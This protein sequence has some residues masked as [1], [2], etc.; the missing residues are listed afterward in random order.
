MK[1]WN[2]I[3]EEMMKNPS[4]TVC[5][6]NAKMNYEELVIF[7]EAFAEKLR[8]EKCCAVLCN[9]E[10]AT[11][12]GLLSC[13]AA[14]VTAVPVSMR[15]GEQHCKKIFDTICPTA[16]ITDMYGE[17]AIL[18]FDDGEY[19]EPDIPPALIM[20]TSGTTGA[21]K[22]AMLSEANIMTNV[23]DICAYF[24]LNTADRILIAR[25]L[26]HCAVLTG[27]F[28]TSL[29][30]GV[31]IRF[32]S[33]AFNPLELLN[34]IAKQEI[35]TFC[36]TPTLLSMLAS[37]LRKGQASTLKNICVSGE[38]MSAETGKK[39]AN[40]FPD[41][42]IYHVY[43]L[44]EAC[45]RVS[46]LSPKEFANKP[47][48]VGF[49]LRSVSLKIITSSG[50]IAKANEIGML[51]VKGE[52]IMTGY[53]N[54]PEQSA[55][56]LCDGWLCT[57]DMALT[58][59]DGFLK[60]KGRSDNL[61]I[62]AGMNIYPQEIEEA[63]KKDKRVREVLAYGYHDDRLGVQIGLK[64]VG[65]F[66]NTDEVKQI[67]KTLLPPFQIPTLIEI[68]NELPKNGSGKIIRP[69]ANKALES[70]KEKQ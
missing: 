29:I 5:E 54:A 44:T 30:K 16:M 15:Y 45:P 24:D 70:R 11:A 59:S 17:L 18:R 33:E 2:F 19:K 12:M 26:Y 27:E 50:D 64:I 13:F 20:C 25:P 36:G 46:Y 31:E 58:D 40:A 4:Q 38:C 39:I 48:S 67:C 21:P 53:Y 23:K 43:G 32:Y 55:R 6:G 60:I 7:S 35:S 65:D 47:D 8:G 66:E 69:K 57:G 41:A 56:V 63:L 22:G 28:L 9:S 49:P 10:M 34:I 52:N 37:F 14:E 3:K 62:R 68:L 1:L 51:Y 61:I 42:N